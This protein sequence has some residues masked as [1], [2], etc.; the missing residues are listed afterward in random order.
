MREESY[1]DDFMERISSYSRPL[2]KLDAYK[3]TPTMREEKNAS[4][5]ENKKQDLY[6]KT[7]TAY[8]RTKAD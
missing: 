1:Y 2:Y 3:T 6:S 7:K 8:W 4:L 5:R